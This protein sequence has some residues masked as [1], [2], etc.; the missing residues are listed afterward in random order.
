MTWSSDKLISF[1]LYIFIKLVMLENTEKKKYR[2]VDFSE[3]QEFTWAM[4]AYAAV[5][6][7]FAERITKKQ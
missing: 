2:G 1:P 4:W 3:V 7:M 6:H 5:S